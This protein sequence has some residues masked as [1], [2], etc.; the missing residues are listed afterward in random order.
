MLRDVIAAPDGQHM[1]GLIENLSQAGVRV[2]QVAVEP[3]ST[4]K[5][6]IGLALLE[7]GPVV[8]GG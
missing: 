6:L 7:S 4:F 1:I 5:P 3:G 2:A 8:L